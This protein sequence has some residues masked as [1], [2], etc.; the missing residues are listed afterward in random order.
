MANL[1]T[2]FPTTITSSAS[3]GTYYGAGNDFT[4]NVNIT[5]T[6]FTTMTRATNGSMFT[7]KIVIWDV[8]AASVVYT[9][10]FNP[11][12]NASST[13]WSSAPY[14]FSTPV[15]LTAGVRY[16][17]MGYTSAG[18]IYNTTA[19][20]YSTNFNTAPKTYRRGSTDTT[21]PTTTGTGLNGYYNLVYNVTAAANTYT[22]TL[23]D[24]IT[25]SDSAITT[26]RIKGN[27]HTYLEDFA[28]TTINPYFTFNGNWIIGSNQL[29]SDLIG[30]NGVTTETITFNVPIGSANATIDFDYYVDSEPSYDWLTI[31][32]NGNQIIR[33]SGTGNAYTHYSS[34]LIAGSQTLELT[35]SKDGSTAVGADKAYFRALQVYYEDGSMGIG[36]IVSTPGQITTRTTS[37]MTNISSTYT[38][39]NYTVLPSFGFA[40]PYYGTFYDNWYLSSNSYFATAPGY[41]YSMDQTTRAIAIARAD[42]AWDWIGYIKDPGGKYITFHFEGRASYSDSVTNLCYDVTLFADGTVQLVTDTASRF[43]PRVDSLSFLSNGVNDSTYLRFTPSAGTSYVFVPKGDNSGWVKYDGASY[44]LGSP[45]QAYTKS[46]SDSVLMD[47]AEQ[48]WQWLLTKNFNS[49]GS[50]QWKGSKFQMKVAKQLK[51]VAAFQTSAS[52]GFPWQ[53]WSCDPTGAQLNALITS[54]TASPNGVTNIYSQVLGTPV[55]LSPGYY[56]IAFKHDGAGYQY[57]TNSTDGTDNAV[58]SS[59]FAGLDSGSTDLFST[60]GISG[61]PGPYEHRLFFGDAAASN[62]FT[63]SLSDSIASADTVTF[64][65]TGFK[66]LTDSQGF[67]DTLTKRLSAFKTLTDSQGSSDTV[68]KRLSAFRTLT[69]S[70]GFSD[71]I[72]K[73]IAAFKTLADSQGFSDTISKQITAFRTL[74]D[75]QG[76]SDAVTKRLTVYKTFTDSQ[77]FTDS[78][79]SGLAFFRSLSDSQGMTDSRSNK[80]SKTYSETQSLSDSFTKRLTAY[81]T[82]TD[83]VASTDSLSKTIQAFKSFTDTIP[84]TEIFSTGSTKNYSK[85]FTESVTLT[86][87]MTERL[88]YLRTLTDSFTGSDTLTKRFSKTLSDIVTASETVQKRFIKTF[89]ESMTLGD[90]ESDLARKTL[91]DSLS[92][93]DSLTRLISKTL[94]DS[95][96]MADAFNRL[97]GNSKLL[98]DTITMV[99]TIRKTI[100]ISKAETVSLADSSY[101]KKIQSI[102]DSI[103]LSESFTKTKGKS[104]IFNETISISESI[105]AR[106]TLMRLLNDAINLSETFDRKAQIEIHEILQTISLDA[107]KQSY[108]FLTAEG[109]KEIS[110]RAS[111][112]KAEV[113][114]ELKKVES[115]FGEINRILQIDSSLKGGRNI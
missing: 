90:S 65:F 36:T 103:V 89:A 74:T 102:L 92:F 97:G 30:N 21:M 66:T 26:N 33:V 113:L 46:L 45:A 19:P 84:V 4:P 38:D 73:Q 78:A 53:L 76:I 6:G 28:D 41:A 69:D 48:S 67:S 80:T 37:G 15:N 3:I 101:K 83:S 59:N 99:D 40:F 93:T 29:T 42:A 25:A 22:V 79:L 27:T 112:D 18:Y 95:Q 55:S 77:G 9:E 13:A 54:G 64:R 20:S 86:D 72:S 98:N 49:G 12:N 107:F 14:N 109:R 96:G 104:L 1:L 8:A 68:T 91:T 94:Q 88:T 87:T 85:L 63:K 56:V 32:L 17:I 11:T 35:Y 114:G 34:S 52:T 31:K 106:R 105:A 44:Q 5:A 58:F 62:N 51:G 2:T 24:S 115:V 10:T 47:D 43:V 100:S 110:L 57:A 75:S 16:S 7:I 111:K 61:N 60:Q 70:Q 39:D 50:P 23:N 82:L 108:I 71:T 81:K